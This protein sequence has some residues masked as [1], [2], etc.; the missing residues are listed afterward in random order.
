MKTIINQTIGNANENALTFNVSI[1]QKSVNTKDGVKLTSHFKANFEVNV[2]RYFTMGQTL[3]RIIKVLN[4]QIVQGKKSGLLKGLSLRN[5]FMFEVTLGDVV[6][7]KSTALEYKAKCGL[8][9]K[10][11]TR[12]YGNVVGQYAKAFNTKTEFYL[13]VADENDSTHTIEDDAALTRMILDMNVC[14]AMDLI[15]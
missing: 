14:D 4:Y 7:F 12:F 9:E 3:N 10:S 13:A 8:T 11:Q 6:I 2:N 5:A 1:N 15:K